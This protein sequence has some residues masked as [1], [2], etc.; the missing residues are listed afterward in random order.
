MPMARSDSVLQGLDPLFQAAVD[1]AGKI[2]AVEALMS[3]E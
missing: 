1:T 3:R 2:V